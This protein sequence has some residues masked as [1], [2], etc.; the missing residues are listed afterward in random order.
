MAKG[1]YRKS[2]S[3]YRSRYRKRY[4]GYAK[5]KTFYYNKKK[6]YPT[7]LLAKLVKSALKAKPSKE[8]FKEKHT[9]V[10]N[11]SRGYAKWL[12]NQ[13]AKELISQV[14]SPWHYYVK[15]FYDETYGPGE[16]PESD[17]DSDEEN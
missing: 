13:K 17:S 9:K 7:K 6:S 16:K 1:K 3:K 12:P 8:E 11:S 4:R 2:G 5:K 14:D 10:W 15:G